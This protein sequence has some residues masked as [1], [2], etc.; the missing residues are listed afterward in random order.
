[1]RFHKSLSEITLHIPKETYPSPRDWRDEI[2]YLIIVDRFSDGKESSRKLYEGAKDNESA[3]YEDGGEKW[4]DSG[5]RWNGGTIR[6]IE[7]KLDYLKGLG[8]TTIWLTPVLRQRADFPQDIEETLQVN[9]HGYAIQNYLDVDPSFGTKE[10]L[11]ELVKAAHDKDIRVILDVV[12]N[13]TGNNWYYKGYKGKHNLNVSPDYR[14][15]GYEFGNW[16]TKSGN[17]VIKDDEDG[18]FPIEFQNTDWYWKKGAIKHWDDYPEYE[19][20]DFFESKSLKTSDQKVLDALIK[21]YRYWI[22]FTDCDGFRL[23]A[24]KHVG[25]DASRKF[26]NAI[27]E[28]AELIGKKN[29]M[30]MGEVAGSEDIA[31]KFLADTTSHGLNAVLDING[32]PRYLEKVIK[33]FEHPFELF[34]YYMPHSTLPLVSHREIGKFHISILDDQDQVWRYPQ[35]G[36]ARFCADNPFPQQVVLATA[37]QL[38]SLGIPA[39]FYG[40]E[41]AFDGQGG[42]PHADRW[43]RECMFGGEFGAKRTKGIHF[44]NPDNPIY[45]EISKL[46]EIRKNEPALRYGRQYFRQISYDGEKFGMPSAKQVIAWSRILAGEEILIAIN[47]SAESGNY[48]WVIVESELHGEN[49]KF[50]CLFSNSTTENPKYFKV[51]QKNTYKA[52]YIPLSAASMC[53]LKRKE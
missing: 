15:K 51:T 24:V 49:A 34:K 38:T 4:R 23:D 48:V 53:I 42:P 40:T 11:R 19:E 43:I 50:E 33:G 20:G 37:F 28:Y 6:G 3:L 44:F 39:I 32:P 29:F 36:K 35:E 21:V 13:H 14:D 26:C 25:L 47:T 12:H 2:L 17:G 52:V 10:D 46:C 27:R 30:L 1:M 5:L 9:Y 22:Y 18:V 8:I 16:R 41:Q 45:K 31:I 7:S